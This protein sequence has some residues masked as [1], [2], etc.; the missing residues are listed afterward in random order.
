MI[1]KSHFKNR[2]DALI[3]NMKLYKVSRDFCTI[4]FG[5][6]GVLVRSIGSA[7]GWFS[8]WSANSDIGHYPAENLTHDEALEFVHRLSKMT[9][10][11]FDLPTEEELRA[12]IEMQKIM[13]YLQQSR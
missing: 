1:Y 2:E 12:E 6:L 11:Q 13:F 3:K 9:N 5:L 8:Q 10:L 7:K 4:P